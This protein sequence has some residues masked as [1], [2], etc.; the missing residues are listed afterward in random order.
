LWRHGAAARVASWP[1]TATI[2]NCTGVTRGQIADAIRSGCAS[3]A[4]CTQMTGAGSVCGSCRSL[5]HELL[6]GAERLR[7]VP[8]AAALALVG[9]LATVAGLALALP[10]NLPDAVSRESAWHLSTLWRD[11]RFK[12][13]TG[14]ALLAAA[15]SS[16]LLSARKRLQLLGRTAFASWRIAHVALGAA[17]LLVLWLHTGGRFGANLNLA[18]AATFVGVLVAGGG[19]SL[20]VANEH[21]FGA[22]ATPLRR[23]SVWLH[24]ALAWPLPV[25]LTFHVL[26]AYIF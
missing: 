16:T 13:L 4:A 2:C 14:Y 9:V 21:R 25:L 20:L 10:W 11:A 15:G 17:A 6:G 3:V 24:L 18:L 22:L 7:S 8:G 23:S 1:H 26:Q 5:L 19:A 12:E